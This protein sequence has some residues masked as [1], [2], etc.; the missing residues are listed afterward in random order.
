MAAEKLTTLTTAQTSRLYSLE[1]KIEKG[2]ATYLQV[3]TALAEIREKRLYKATHATWEA[4]CRGRWKF[5]TQ[6]CGRLM[7]AASFAEQSEPMGSVPATERAA[8]QAIADAADEVFRSLPADEQL[9]LCRADEARAGQAREARQV[10][11]GDG[12]GKRIDQALRLSARVRKLVEGI[13]P[14]ADGALAAHQVFLDQLNSI[15]R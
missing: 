3:G 1:E 5:S 6:H 8:R 13:G 12:R 7:A 14:E 11:G 2:R 15:E 10:A 4:Y 9:K